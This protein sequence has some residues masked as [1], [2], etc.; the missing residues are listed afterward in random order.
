MDQIHADTVLVHASVQ[1]VIIARTIPEIRRVVRGVRLVVLSLREQAYV[2]A[3]RATGANLCR[4]LGRHILSNMLVPLSAQGTYICA[5]AVLFEAYEPL[6]LET[7]GGLRGKH[8]QGQGHESR[9]T[10]CGRA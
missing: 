1:N 5:S 4:L 3:S 9:R 10:P 7:V 6:C 2:D 8:P